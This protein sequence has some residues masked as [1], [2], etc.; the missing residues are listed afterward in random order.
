MFG[1]FFSLNDIQLKDE[2]FTNV[3]LRRK[4]IPHYFF[5]KTLFVFGFMLLF[6]FFIKNT[7]H[8]QHFYI[9]LVWLKMHIYIYKKKKVKKWDSNYTFIAK[10]RN[11]NSKRL[12]LCVNLHMF[13]SYKRFDWQCRFSVIT[14]NIHLGLDIFGLNNKVIEK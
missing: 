4:C 13:K 6:S 1:S 9:K 5:C 3:V 11:K 2:T 7:I 10:A 8:L 14:R 12:F